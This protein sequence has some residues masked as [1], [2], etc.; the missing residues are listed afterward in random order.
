MP[1]TTPAA[2]RAIL[3]A[4]VAANEAY[5]KGE[6]PLMSDAQYDAAEDNLAEMVAVSDPS[7]PDVIA[8]KA[9]LAGIGAAPADNSGWLKVRHS[10]R[11]GV[12]LQHG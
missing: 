5:R 2:S 4:L 10:A 1:I 6:V 11:A 3:A 9:F 12:A 8:A 7:D